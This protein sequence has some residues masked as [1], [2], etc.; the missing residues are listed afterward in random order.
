M[1]LVRG[2]QE[3]EQGSFTADFVPRDSVAEGW[4]AFR[5]N[6]DSGELSAA[7]RGFEKP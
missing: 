6:P 5:E 3:V 7:V 4:V 2:G 1:T